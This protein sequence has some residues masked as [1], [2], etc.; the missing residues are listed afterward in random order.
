[1][2]PAIPAPSP[3]SLPEPLATDREGTHGGQSRSGQAFL[4]IPPLYW[5]R[6]LLPF[7]PLPYLR[8]KPG[9]QLILVPAATFILDGSLQP[10]SPLQPR[11]LELAAGRAS[12]LTTVP[13]GKNALQLPAP[14]PPVMVQSIPA[15]WEVI[16]PLPV[17][18]GTVEMLP[19]AAANAVCTVMVE[20]LVMPP[21]DAMIVDDWLL[22][23]L[24]V[25]TAKVVLVDPEGTV[26][27]AG[28]V[29]AAVL[30]L[31]S[32]TTSPPDGAAEVRVMVPVAE[33][34]P[35]TAVGLRLRVES[36]AWDGALTVQPDSLAEA[37][38]VDPSFTF[39]MQSSGF[40]NG[41]RSILKAP[42][43][44]LVPMATPLTVIVLLAA[45]WPSIR[46]FVPLSSARDADRGLCRG[47]RD[48]QH[49]Q[50]R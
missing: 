11:K 46:G 12:S 2:L 43:P 45:A 5:R 44:S 17:P 31:D 24:L 25:D 35:T 27:L 30:L 19:F 15:G 47:Y 20:D 29:A 22:L 36:D 37:A 7:I 40:G 41:S 39:T 18:P 6:W 49:E 3:R 42:V 38:V 21:A 50:S 23:T 28:N 9:W 13:V 26:T 1:M 8:A 10:G 16:R 32:E 14:L 34:P 33:S 4:A 48:D